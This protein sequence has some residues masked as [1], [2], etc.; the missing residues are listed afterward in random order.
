MKTLNQFQCEICNTVYKS[1]SECLYCER[2]HKL[3]VEIIGNKFNSYKNSGEYPQRI[4]VKMSDNKEIT[5][6]R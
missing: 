4:H 5:Y 2:T 6:S 3:P 1:E